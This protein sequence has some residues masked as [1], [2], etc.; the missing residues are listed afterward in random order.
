ML[1]EGGRGM[2]GIDKERL[3]VFTGPKE[4]IQRY[5]KLFDHLRQQGNY[6]NV[7]VVPE[8][9]EVPVLITPHWMYVGRADIEHIFGAKEFLEED[10]G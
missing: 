7:I 1:L 6:V 2:M 3:F 9:S 8:G 10:E 5:Q 4:D